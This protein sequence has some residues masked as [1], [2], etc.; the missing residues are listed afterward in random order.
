M[1]DEILPIEEQQWLERTWAKRFQVQ[2]FEVT[3]PP[4]P[5]EIDRRS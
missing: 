1:E 2:G 3:P 4:R 5:E